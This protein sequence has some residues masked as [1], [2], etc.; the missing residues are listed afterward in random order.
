MKCPKC[1]FENPA[2]THLCGK[3]GT[4]LRRKSLIETSGPT[5][6]DIPVSNTK[7]L[8]IPV[9]KLA[10]GSTFAG[11]YE[12]IE[13]LGKGGMGKVYRV[14]DKKIEEEV[15]LKILNPEIAAHKE[16]IERFKNELKF[17]RKISHRNVCRMYDLS[18]EKETQFIT[19]EY[20]PGEDLKSLIKR[21]GSITIE[22]SIFLAR[23]VCDGLA[24]AHRLGVVHRDLKPQNI[25][26]DREGNA[27]IMDFGIARSADTKG[28][29]EAGT[30]I[31]TPDYMSPEQVEGKEADQRSDIYSLGVI[32]FEMVTGRVLFEG[33]NAL[34]VALKHK[35]EAPTD[36]REF[37]D[38]VPDDLSRM[39]LKCIEKD[40][41]KRYQEA[42]KL[43]YE[44]EKIRVKKPEP[45][46][47]TE[48]K[49]KKSIAVLPFT[50]LSSERD[51]EYFCN[52]MAEELIIALTKIERLQVASRTWAFQFKGKGY[53]MDEIGRKLK[54]ESVLEGSV[55]KAGNRLRI[56]AQLINVVDGFHIWSEKYDRN[57]EDIF[58][59]QDEISLAIVDK[60][61]VKLLGEEKE[62]LVKRHTDNLGAYNLYLK[63]R[64]FWNRRYEGGL[65]KGLEHFKQAI[66]KDPLYALAYSG[67]ADC[68]NLLGLYGSL[69][70]KKAYPKAKAAA[71]K[72]VETDNKLA[73][74]HASLGFI[75]MFFD[76]DWAGA[77]KEFRQAF[78]LNPDYATAHE[79]YALYL[80]IIGRFDE[81][82]AEVRR[83]QELDPLSIIISA[84][85]GL[86]F[87]LA[88]RYDEA[89]EQY[90]KTFEMDPNFS[91]AH[92]YQ[93]A[94]YADKAMWKEAIAAW[95]K[96]VTVTEGS[97]FAVGY[98]G[99]GYA[100]S[101]QRNE[102]LEMIDR[103]RELSEEK[104][105]S[106]FSYSLIYM[107]LGE[108]DQTFD[109]LEKA[110]EERESFLAF[111]KV[112]PFFDSFRPD[113]RFK[114][115]LRKMGLE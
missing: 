30:I 80:A 68:Y 85:V 11:R 2:D 61:K 77:E 67:I 12:V 29:T 18:E 55:R 32:L 17:A 16:T 25:M 90:N 101:G 104:Y 92:L 70:P 79:W 22:K 49:R 46:K 112:W 103:L 113:P 1:Y 27:R 26:I 10:R 42:G 14:V 100:M 48:I 28:I 105:V 54:V 78:D 73:E 34:S 74:A 96:L 38:Q 97:P 87:Y 24:E 95:K 76:W 3:C 62:A 36:P 50:D 110:Y 44:L 88:R 43:L 71:E 102:A 37:N 39:I 53:D 58:A 9:N 66:N 84:I 31:G 91:I 52:G 111:F 40:K 41:E 64:Y 99:F 114:A 59:I 51:Q 56:T 6:N 13:E 107:G 35:T 8:Q 89:I 72:A 106:P 65:Q 83:A 98:L 57:M 7:T 109:Y 45:G 60:L 63:G 33:D 75:G 82:L 86:I 19:M 15:A 108:K 47:I 20:V 81:A 21:M 23:Q 69:P 94:A 5:D 93:G 115:L 4:E